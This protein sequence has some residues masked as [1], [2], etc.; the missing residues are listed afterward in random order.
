MYMKL[1]N[2]ATREEKKLKSESSHGLQTVLN[3]ERLAQRLHKH[4]LTLNISK[5]KF[6]LISGPKKSPSKVSLN[7]KDKELDKVSSYMYLG[8]VINKTLTWDN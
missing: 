1:R 6:M 4:K 8:E 7:I 3:E 5:S 2:Y